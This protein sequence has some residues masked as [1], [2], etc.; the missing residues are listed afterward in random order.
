V[1]EFKWFIYRFTSPTM[2][3]LF[4]NPR[5]FLQVESALVAMLAGDVFDSPRVKRRLRLFRLIYAA[6]VLSMVPQ[7]FK[8]W[9]R[10]RC[11]PAEGFRGETLQPDPAGQA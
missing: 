8:A 4:A 5:D 2:R 6:H 9:R 10:R 1:R 11:Q 7:A 3:L